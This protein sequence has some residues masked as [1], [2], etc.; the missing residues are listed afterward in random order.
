MVSPS[1]TTAIAQVAQTPGI[2]GKEN[3]TVLFEFSKKSPEGLDDINRQWF[4]P[5]GFSPAKM[6]IFS[7]DPS[8]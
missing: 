2:S 7:S 1:Y 6:R 3:N 5:D 4:Y 8:S